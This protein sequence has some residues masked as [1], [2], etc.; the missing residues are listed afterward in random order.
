MLYTR[1]EHRDLMF[2]DF[3][4][5]FTGDIYY[6]LTVPALKIICPIRALKKI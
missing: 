4:N 6:L 1:L 3:F 2:Q 5:F